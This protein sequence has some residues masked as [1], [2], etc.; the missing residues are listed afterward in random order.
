MGKFA[1]RLSQHNPESKTLS[2]KL[3]QSL[4]ERLDDAALQYECKRYEFISMALEFAL[5]DLQENLK[6]ELTPRRKVDAVTSSKKRN[7]ESSAGEQAK[8]TDSLVVS[9]DDD[10]ED[11]EPG[12][13][14]DIDDIESNELDDLAEDHEKIVD[15]PSS[16]VDDEDEG[17]P[18]VKKRRASTSTRKTT[19][20]KTTTKVRSGSSARPA[21]KPKD[22]DSDW[23]EEDW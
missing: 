16:D 20:R 11:E 9:E 14:L 2:V 13:D 3:P 19:G 6:A 8:S 18:P 17:Q 7:P 12:D 4:I 23:D 1:D 10:I 5:D 22:S 15:V 21:A